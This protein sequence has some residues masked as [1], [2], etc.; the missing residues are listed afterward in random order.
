[1]MRLQIMGSRLPVFTRFDNP[2]S[3]AP[4]PVRQLSYNYLISVNL[5]LMLFPCDLCCDWTMGTVP[6]VESLLDARNLVTLIS[7][8]ILSLLTYVAVV[9]DNRQQATVII[10]V[11]K[12]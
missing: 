7:Y 1:M 11:R 8:A 4:T 6:L 12:K 5:W 2:A 10:M 9:T 3:V